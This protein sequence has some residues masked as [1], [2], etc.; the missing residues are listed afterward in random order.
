MAI[1]LLGLIIFLGLHSTRIFAESGR[2]KAIARLGEGPWKGI[3]SLLSA[4]GF[5]LI[6]WGFADARFTA[7][8]LYAPPPGARHATILLMLV[9]MVLLAA[10]FFKRSHITAALHHPMVWSVAV[11]G[12]AHLVANGV[13]TPLSIPSRSG[14]RPPARWR[15]ESPSGP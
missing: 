3:Y 14:A 12:A 1:L 5:V 15:S 10:Y 11:F 8:T 13:V 6:V 7:P 9:A 2:E 4:I